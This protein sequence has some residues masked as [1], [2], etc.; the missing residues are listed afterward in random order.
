MMTCAGCKG[1]AFHA[2]EVPA[3]S[4]GS[5][6]RGTLMFYGLPLLALAL[7]VGLAETAGLSPLIALLL[8]TG[9]V[10]GAAA[11]IKGVVIRAPR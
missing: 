7:A 8:C 5:L 1:C 9:M 4:R 11:G 2:A 6:L 10:A 3:E